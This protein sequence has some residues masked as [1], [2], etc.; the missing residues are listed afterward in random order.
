MRL[1]RQRIIRRCELWQRSATFFAQRRRRGFD[2]SDLWSLD[3]TIAVFVLPRLRAF[4]QQ[5]HGYP[6]YFDS[7]EAWH[8]RID[9]MI[10]AFD[11]IVRQWDDDYYD[12]TTPDEETI[13]DYRIDEGLRLFGEYM[14]HLWT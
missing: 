7:I 3:H 4:R 1:S 10:Y 11:Q 9:K 8:W 12:S 13:R 14:G 6:G 2:D 5:T